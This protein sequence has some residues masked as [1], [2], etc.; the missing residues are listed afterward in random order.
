MA[1]LLVVSVL[2]VALIG[3]MQAQIVIDAPA[4]VPNI[5]SL[6]DIT[7]N[8]PNLPGLPNMPDM[9][10]MPSMPDM[11]NMP[12]MPNMPD[13]P[14]MPS[15]PNMPGIPNNFLSG[16]GDMIRQIP[17]RGMNMIEQLLQSVRNFVPSGL[18]RNGKF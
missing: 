4:V 10:G 11:P 17:A 9:P 13:M 2:L 16:I 14:S 1:T 18:G 15:M 5:P 7:N 6:S 8:I 3:S 12:N